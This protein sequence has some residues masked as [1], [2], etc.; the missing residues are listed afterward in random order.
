MTDIKIAGR[1]VGPGHPCY[2]IAEIG[3]NNAGSV[4]L[5]IKMIEAAAQAGVDAVKF[6]TYRTSDLSL[7]SW[8]HFEL[9][10]HGEMDAAAHAPLAEAARKLG[11]HFLSTPFS[12]EA[13][14]ILEGVDVPA[15]KIASMDLTNQ[16][17]LRRV[18]R[19]GKPVI[20]STGM[21]TVAEI[22]EA[23]ETVFAEGN[24]QLVL[25]HCVSHYPPAPEAANVRTMQQ[26]AEAFGLPT[27]YSDHVLGNAASL[28][29]V[30]LGACVIEKHFT[31]DKDMDGPDHK[32]SAD[33]AEMSALIRDIRQV[34][35]ALGRR[36]ADASR[37]DRAQG[38]LARRGLYA[39]KDIAAG[40]VITADMVKCVRP[41]RGLAPKYLD[42][43]I[44][45]TARADVKLEEP[46]TFDAI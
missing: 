5:G 41:A 42:L 24:R 7:Q 43:V 17:L 13:V 30:A 46:I 14:D 21:S 4:D 16:P 11:V 6:Q 45:R 18:A 29:A 34:E 32:I 38:E 36:C 25:L 23:V 20:L 22:G 12:D 40:T 10:R 31:I 37:A 26:I 39:A 9:V 1:P 35:A 2:V 8:E 28:A 3:F 33:P 44:G 15:Y 27:G 19:L